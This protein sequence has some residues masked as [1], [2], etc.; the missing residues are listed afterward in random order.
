MSKRFID[1]GLFDDDWFMDL[2]K[3]A[4]LLW[5][6]FITKCNHAGMIKLNPK[7]C[8]VQTDIKELETV[9]KQLGNRLVTVSEHLYF[10]P[11]F[12]DFQYPGFPNSKVRS[13]ISAIAILKKHGLIDEENLTLIKGLDNSYEHE[14]DN[15]NDND[16]GGM[17]GKNKII[18]QQF[19]D[20]YHLITGLQKTDLQAAQKYWNK[21]S[22]TERQ[23]AIKNIKPYYDSLKDK[24]YCKKA[25]TY[26]A[27]KNF[28]DEFKV[29]GSIPEYGH[30]IS[31]DLKRILANEQ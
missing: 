13:Q 26:L 25:R 31:S 24:K 22:D 10:I 30:P 3:D 28:N 17:G 29:N 5:I 11:K 4:K 23:K 9:I 1:T 7:L 14:H 20:S 16:K 12:I 6:Y 27:D 8:K 19:W 18:F 21:L 2:S 15:D